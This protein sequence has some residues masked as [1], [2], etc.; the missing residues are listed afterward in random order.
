MPEIIEP[1]PI[2]VEMVSQRRSVPRLDEL[3]TAFQKMVPEFKLAGHVYSEDA[4]LRM[5]LIN[6]RIVRENGAAAK[7]F[8]LEEITPDGIIIRNGT[9]RF[10]IDVP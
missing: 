2:P 3:D 9:V 1:Q 5:I 4:T 6:N 7:D 8:I 10:R